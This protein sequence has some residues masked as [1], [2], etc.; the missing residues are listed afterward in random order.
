M[1]STS[2]HNTVSSPSTSSTPTIL[3]L[4]TVVHGVH[5]RLTVLLCIHL[6]GM[7]F[8]VYFPTIV[9]SF[10]GNCDSIGADPKPSPPCYLYLQV[11]FVPLS[12]PQLQRP[13]SCFHSPVISAATRRARRSVERALDSGGIRDQ[14]SRI[15]KP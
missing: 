10:T 6:I 12:S 9:L 7:L 3:P 11:A 8:S 5:D 15:P 1:L 13:L 2:S 4:L 14:K